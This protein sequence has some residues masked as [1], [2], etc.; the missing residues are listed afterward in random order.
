M[1]KTFVLLAIFLIPALV[2]SSGIFVVNAE[3]D[4][5]QR[6]PQI[7][8]DA[9]G[10]YIVVWNTVQEG[11]AGDILYS[12]FDA[13]DQRLGSDVLVNTKTG[14]EQEKPA[15]SMNNAGDFIIAWT[16]HDGVDSLYDIKARFY[17]QGLAIGPEFLVNQT[18][19]FSQ[20]NPDAAIDG[21]G[22]FVIVWESWFQDGS[23]R[24]VFARLY[25]SDGN[26][27]G[28]PFQV[29]TTTE[30]SQARP[31]VKY[32]DD[33]SFV[34]IWESWMQDVL[35][36]SGYGI[37]GQLFTAAG[38]KQGAEFQI[39]TYTNDYQWFGDV[40]TFS[41]K[42]FIV[43][44]TSW[45]QD[46]NK[47]GIYLQKFD[48][49]AQR[50]GDEK[51][52][53]ETTA[54]CQ[55][56]PRITKLNEEKVAV[57]WS[58]WKQ[59]GSR[60]GVFAR[61]FDYKNEKSS[62]EMQVNEHTESFQWEPD[63]IAVSENEA[64]VT[65]S[66]WGQF[67]KDYEV[68]AKHITPVFPQG[69]YKAEAYEHAAGKSTM[70]FK[71][72]VTDSSALSGDTY[73]ISFSEIKSASFNV[74]IKNLNSASNVFTD[75]PINKGEGVFYLTP[76]FDGIAVQIFP[77]FDFSLDFERSYFKN[78]S[79]SNLIQ[80]LSYPTLGTPLLAPV[81]VALVWGSTDTLASGEYVS[82]SDTA[83]GYY[84]NVT[85]PFRAVDLATGEK[86]DL[87]VIEKSSTKNGKW[88]VT[89]KID[90]MTPLPYREISSN[91]H[92][93]VTTNLPGETL[94]LPAEGDTYF[95]YT[96]RPV[97]EEDRFRF[98]TDSGF[99]T[100][101]NTLHSPLKTFRLEQNY[102]NPFNPVTTIPYYLPQPGKIRLD[103]YDVLGAHVVQ[104]VNGWQNTGRHKALF[105]GS[106]LSSGMY[107]VTLRV[108]QKVFIR[109]VLLIK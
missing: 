104:L 23:D 82:P 36:E 17:K 1:R 35:T 78:L 75:F 40:E 83:S 4:S 44:W 50:V 60:D 25:D 53:N 18:I 85:V 5:T 54:F 100:G 97:K 89:E 15:V 59:D 34:V 64:L 48:S 94:I 46:G 99:S 93:E 41:D 109:R 32:F 6:D 56:L 66:D 37:Y 57:V 45:Q 79:G 13:S 92:A 12:L 27:R 52:V 98:T 55:W 105:D 71:V 91:T 95:I 74:N 24:G 21:N 81:D 69:Y 20:T 11:D 49:A 63:L 28:E 101:I 14:G 22:N 42:S 77:E 2:F 90:I 68:M 3:M 62:F 30:Y 73:E 38:I 16:S 107:F 43:V 29:N 108:K 87:F 10:N 9:Q 39:N 67:N 70:H 102:P 26:S 33:G 8:R 65:W 84:G 61:F 47:G 72:H 76:A 88:D 51:I 86:L 31:V 96:N 80:T 7:S 106:Q 19:P 103:V 58:S